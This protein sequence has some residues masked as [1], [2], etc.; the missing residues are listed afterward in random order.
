MIPARWKVCFSEEAE[1]QFET[2]GDHERKQIIAYIA[3]R[4]IRTPDPGNLGKTLKGNL[5]TYWRY[6]VGDCRFICDI[7]KKRL[8][9]AVL[10]VSCCR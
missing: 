9:I 4:L 10:K 7:E 1:K 6:R 8:T 2:L 5:S 3:E